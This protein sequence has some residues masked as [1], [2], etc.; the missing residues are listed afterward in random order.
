MRVTAGNLAVGVIHTVGNL[1]ITLDAGNLTDASDDDTTTREADIRST[2]IITLD[3]TGD[4]GSLTDRLDIRT[5]FDNNGTSDT[6]DD[7]LGSLSGSVTGALYI[8]AVDDD[9]VFA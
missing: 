1:N 6:S 2:G 5:E 8:S 9:P 4:V 3:I 7:T